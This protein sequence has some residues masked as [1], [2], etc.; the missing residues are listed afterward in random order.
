MKIIAIVNQK[1][2]WL[3]TTSSLNIAVGL[4]KKVK[5]TLLILTHKQMQLQVLES[6]K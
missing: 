1:E 6:I 3:K 5:S 4:G 2:E